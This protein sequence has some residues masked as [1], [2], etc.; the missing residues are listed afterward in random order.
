MA[1]LIEDFTLV[2]INLY[3]DT[4]FSLVLKCPVPL[5]TINPGQF[6][7]VLVPNSKSVF[8]RRPFSIFH[9]NYDNNTISFLIKEKGKGTSELKDTKP[10]QIINVIFPLG[11]SFSEPKGDNVLLVGGGVGI[12]PMLMLAKKL[13][14]QNRNVD[15]LYGVVNSSEIVEKYFLSKYSKLH[16]CTDDG[17]EGFKGFVTENP[18]LRQNIDKYDSIYVCGPDVMMKKVAKIALDR[19]IHCQVSLENTMACGFGA[20]LCCV[21]E[22]VNGNKNTCTDGPVFDAFVLT[23][24]NK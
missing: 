17:S 4:L 16:I 5:P 7:Q 6:A 14:E 10:N 21:A 11:N 15:V 23:N 24:F 1:K 22:T 13:H 8:L 20:C 19:N 2:D 9:V 18:I 12:A 3:S